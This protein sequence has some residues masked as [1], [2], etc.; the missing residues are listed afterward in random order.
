M[1]GFLLHQGATVLCAHAGD[2]QPTMPNPR[3]LVGGMPT[4]TLATPYVVAGCALP[5]PPA[6]NGPCITAQFVTG[7]LRVTSNGQPLLLLDS[8]AICAPTGTPLIVAATQ[9][10]VTGM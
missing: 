9:T 7:A 2:A 6:A 3:V 8:Q 4:T 10:R 5:P 1:P